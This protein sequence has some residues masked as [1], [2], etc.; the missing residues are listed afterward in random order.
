MQLGRV[1]QLE[2]NMP[3]FLIFCLVVVNLCS[4]LMRQFS[5]IQ[6]S[7]ISLLK[8]CGSTLMPVYVGT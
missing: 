3:E 5:Q 1:K 2:H 7:F 8:N 6:E 4:Y